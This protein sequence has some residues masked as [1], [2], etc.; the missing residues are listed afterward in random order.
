MEQYNQ[1]VSRVFSKLFKDISAGHDES[2]NWVHYLKGN[3][4]ITEES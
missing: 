2:G 1:R 3:V 4:I